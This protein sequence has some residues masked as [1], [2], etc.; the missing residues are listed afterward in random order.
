[1]IKPRLTV[2]L[3]PKTCW[4]ENVK[5]HVSG[6]EWDIIRK[7]AYAEANYR[8]EI[9]NGVGMRWP[10]ECHEHWHYDDICRIKTLIKMMALC[11]KCHKVKHITRQ[12]TFGQFSL[13]SHM[14]NVNKWT[15][16]EAEFYLKEAFETWKK[17]S[18]HK[19]KLNIDVLSEYFIDTLK[20]HKY[21][22]LIG[23]TEW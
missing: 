7:K 12:F 5:S 10:V 15:K 22:P 17:R 9:C 14:E 23:E 8:C 20:D 11:P 18:K 6:E 16:G 21:K 2:E 19:W 13:I 4:Y 1:M 3:N